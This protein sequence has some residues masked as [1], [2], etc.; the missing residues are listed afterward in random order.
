MMFGH[1]SSL[2]ISWPRLNG[3][4]LGGPHLHPAARKERGVSRV[5]TPGQTTIGPVRRRFQDRPV[6]CSEDPELICA[7]PDKVLP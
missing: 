3:C 4:S 1:G 2:K 5:P 7:L 6:A